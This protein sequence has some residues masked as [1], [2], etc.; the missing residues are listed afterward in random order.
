MVYD[1]TSKQSFIRANSWI[2]ELR[3]NGKPEILIALAG[4][5]SDL[6]SKREVEYDAVNDFAEENSLIFKETSAKND[7][8]VKEVFM[9]IA[10]K[11]SKIHFVEAKG[12]KL[13]EPAAGDNK[14]GNCCKK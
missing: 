13:L 3:Q 11:I 8:N 9:D 10:Q 4:N 6:G 2:R 5:K 14:K 1:I 7:S 12:T